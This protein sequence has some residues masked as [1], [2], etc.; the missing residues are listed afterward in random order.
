MN[1]SPARS[2]LVHPLLLALLLAFAVRVLPATLNYVIGTDEALYLTLAGHLAA[3][4]G[5]TAD[6]VHPHSEFDPGYPLVAALVYRLTGTLPFSPAA[7]DAFW[8]E[9]P[10]RLN[11]LLLGSL[12]VVPVYYLARAF[13][14]GDPAFATRAALLTAV[15]PALALGVPNFEAAS[16]Q[17]Y[18][19][20]LWCAWLFLWL[21]L[22]RRRAFWFLLAGLGFG[23]AHLTRWEGLVSAGAALVVTLVAFRPAA[24]IPIRQLAAASL[25]LLIGVL[26]IA[27]PYAAYQTA[28]TGS[29]FSTKSI[30]HQLHGEALASPDPFAWEKAYDNYERVRDNPG[31]Y[32]PLPVYLWEH[33]ELTAVNYV[34]NTITQLRL[35]FTS[36]TFLF[37]LW[38]PFALLGARLESEF[39]P[40]TAGGKFR[41]P[42]RRN[43]FLAASLLPALIFPLSV[44]D[45]RYLLPLFPA[46]MLW[47]ARGLAP[48]DRTVSAR[49][50]RTA[51][52]LPVVRF[53]LRGPLTALLL[54]L[55]VAADLTAP[56]FIPRPTEYR[57]AG[58]ALRG[59]LPP[60]APV[61]MRKRQFAFYA[62]V[63]Y[64]SLPFADL[65]GVLDY[66]AKKGAS[67]IVVDERTTPATRPMLVYLLTPP[68]PPPLELFY[69]TSSGV[70]LIVYQ[71]AAPVS[72]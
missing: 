22:A 58:L 36:P 72:P 67:Y 64:E 46:G 9:L 45:A 61:L 15:V 7:R 69:R 32:P 5:F 48:A 14:P 12:L 49:L 37:V 41:T 23:I 26:F 29:I 17:L 70:P 42:R 52:R 39:S 28:R 38:L 30:V 10:A 18:S 4:D 54:A 6:G 44:V 50:A 47:T 19:L 65:P 66:A 11:L 3:G 25:A 34:K 43:L 68:P 33:R 71:I 62:N 59:A 40:C 8:L 31:L 21:G 1:A 51:D 55:F 16:E 53:F 27:A 63:S 57:D 60:Q 2:R 24:T 35:I 13:S 20:A 56:F